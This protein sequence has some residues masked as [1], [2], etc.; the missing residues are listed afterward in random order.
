VAAKNDKN[1]RQMK[2]GMK[3]NEKKL[4]IKKMK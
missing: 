2:T 1:K 4:I 3:M